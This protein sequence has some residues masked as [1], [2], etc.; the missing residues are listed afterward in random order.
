MSSR[1]IGLIERLGQDADLQFVSTEAL[2]H[3]FAHQELSPELASALTSGDQ[4]RLASLLGAD[5]NISCMVFPA[6][7]D[8]EDDQEESPDED[9]KDS[10]QEKSENG[11]QR[12]PVKVNVAS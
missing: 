1:V 7:E 11:P 2:M 4:R 5:T 8:E 6:K 12:R 3:A 9:D 10:P